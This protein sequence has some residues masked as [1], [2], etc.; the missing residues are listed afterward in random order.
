[1]KRLGKNYFFKNIIPVFKIKKK[2]MDLKE[3]LIEKEN[4]IEKNFENKAYLNSSYFNIFCFKTLAVNFHNLKI[5][6]N[7]NKI[8]KEFI[9]I[10]KKIKNPLELK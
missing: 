4:Q 8:K 1:M 6:Y 2:K 7:N 5:N 10:K 3:E 9:L